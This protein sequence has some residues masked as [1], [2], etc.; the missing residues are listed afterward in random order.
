MIKLLSSFWHH[1]MVQTVL[2]A[3]Q[4]DYINQLLI[5]TAYFSLLWCLCFFF[6]VLVVKGSLSPV[7]IIFYE[8]FLGIKLN[9]CLREGVILATGIAANSWVLLVLAEGQKHLSMHNFAWIVTKALNRYLEVEI[10]SHCLLHI[11][12]PD[13]DVYRTKKGHILKGQ[14]WM[15]TLGGGGEGGKWNCPIHL[16]KNSFFLKEKWNLFWCLLVSPLYWQRQIWVPRNE[17]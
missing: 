2:T 8:L 16:N 14:P 17:R 12:K 9:S 10:H 1:A 15:Q 3:Y 7:M 11:V 13:P 4:F 6:W 5:T